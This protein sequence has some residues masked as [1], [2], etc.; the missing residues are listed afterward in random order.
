MLS[1]KLLQR[2]ISALVIAPVFIYIIYLGNTVFLALLAIAFLISMWEWFALS[3]KN[4]YFVPCFMIGL[5]YI[6]LSFASFYALRQVYDINAMWVFIGMIWFSDVGAYFIGK[7][8]G[9]PKLIAIISPNK[10]WS[11]FF[12]ALLFP[13]MFGTL[14]IYFFGFLD[15]FK[16]YP[17]FYALPMAF[18]IGVVMGSVGQAGDLMVSVVKRMAKVKDTGALI[19][20]HGGLLDRIDSMLL[21]APVY[22]LLITLMSYVL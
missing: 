8:I 12:G 10:T 17:F 7:T 16:S 4:E 22:F 6:S 14:W 1:S 21:G 20:G 3:K 2:T 15:E 9:G 13:A 11:G 18:I 19:P 5:V